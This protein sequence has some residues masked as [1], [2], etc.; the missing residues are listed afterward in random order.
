M[1]SSEHLLFIFSSHT[2]LANMIKAPSQKKK[3]Q[4]W[5]AQKKE[6]KRQSIR[7]GSHEKRSQLFLTK[8]LLQENELVNNNILKSLFISLKHVYQYLILPHKAGRT[9]LLTHLSDENTAPGGVH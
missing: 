2:Q 8:E 5:N 4:K 1:V 3:D 6:D 9:A 7:C